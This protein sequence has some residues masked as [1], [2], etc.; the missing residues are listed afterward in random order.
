M[1]ANGPMDF[2]TVQA[3]VTRG[4]LAGA[5]ALVEAHLQQQ[6]QSPELLEFAGLLAWR[7]GSMPDLVAHLRQLIRVKPENDAAR[8]NLA[9]ALV[10]T[11]A[12]DEAADL[13]A[14]RAGDPRI[15]RLLGY[16]HQ[17]KG[18]FAAAV[19]SYEQVLAAVPDDV[20]SWN[21][22]A[23]A[24]AALGDFEGARVAFGRALDLR[25][26]LIPIYIN[27]SEVLAK[28]DRI[29]ARRG[30]MREAA[31]RAPSDAK[32][33]AELGLAETAARD[34]DRATDAFRRAIGIDRGCTAAFLELGLMFENLNRID[35]LAAVVAQ[36]ES[37][38]LASAEI[39]FLKAWLLRR[40]GHFAEALSLAEKTPGTISPIRRA[41]LLAE[42]YDRSGK[43]Q[44]AFDNFLE[45]NRQ[46]IAAR[47]AATVRSYRERVEAEAQLITPASTSAWTRVELDTTV[48]APIFIVGFPRSGTTLLDTLL[49][50]LPQ[51]HVME[52]LPVLRGVQASLGGIENLATLTSDLAN[53]LRRRYF[54]VAGELTEVPPGKRL[55]D[56]FPLHLAELPLIHRLFPDAQVVLVE[57]HPCDAVL[58]C[59]MAN[60]QLND[61]M[62]SFTS[63]DE[64]ARTYHAVF[65]AFTRATDVW[66]IDVHRVRYEHMVEDLEAEMRPLLAFLGLEWDDRVLDNRASAAKRDHI[67][68]AS[69]SQVTEP[70]Y[71]R[72][73]GRWERYRPQMSSVLPILAPW[74]E[75]LGYAI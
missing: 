58:S 31:R 6:P 43:S 52:E 22:L 54:E 66:S 64:A 30:L 75:R 74:A 14:E 4:D 17:S 67:R 40:Q 62:R 63:L 56:K 18:E 42:L 12:L 48:G 33:W 57:R 72:A 23:N 27:A 34:F 10:S 11:G 28:L 20:E 7:A 61:G 15:E 71:K 70:I 2:A 45:M 16:I 26:D 39:G 53:D 35:D 24:R 50:N 68:T 44:L 29:E 46:A 36:A 25:P 5:R 13:C 51:L 38:G 47:P 19:R 65:D 21:N 49:M 60:F 8:L 1:V 59:F 32:V 73:A 9:G 41:Q 55:V 37:N 69:Y 3:M